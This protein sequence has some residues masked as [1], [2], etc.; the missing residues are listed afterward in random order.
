MNP[1]RIFTTLWS[2][3]TNMESKVEGQSLGKILQV[4]SVI[5]TAL[6]VYTI[7]SSNGNISVI[8]TLVFLLCTCKHCY[9]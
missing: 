6:N 5:S 1:D 9:K 4:A 3:I 8:L 2:Q 7:L